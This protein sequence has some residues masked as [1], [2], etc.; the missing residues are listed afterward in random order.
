[1]SILNILHIVRLTVV[2]FWAPWSDPCKQMNEVMQELSHDQENAKF[3][4]V[5]TRK[6]DCLNFFSKL[7]KRKCI[8]MFLVFYYHIM[9]Y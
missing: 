3:I 4:K 1:M 6:S 9:G 7:N 2:H 5:S 8:N